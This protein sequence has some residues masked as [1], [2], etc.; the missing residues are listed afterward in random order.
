MHSTWSIPT[1]HILNTSN[2]FRAGGDVPAPRIIHRVDPVYPEDARKARIAGSLIIE[3]V[4][5]RDGRIRD[6]VVLKSIPILDDAGLTAVRQWTFEPGTLD[7][8]PVDVI[9][10]LVVNFSVAP[11][12]PEPR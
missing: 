11:S 4:I 1:R 2:A 12:A 8:K 7:G 10:N 5:G 3:A 6:A 9:Y